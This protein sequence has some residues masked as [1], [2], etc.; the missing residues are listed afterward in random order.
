[1]VRE[2]HSVFTVTCFYLGHRYSSCVKNIRGLKRFTISSLG[3]Y[4]SHNLWYWVWFSLSLSVSDV[5]II[6]DMFLAYL[7]H[8][9]HL[10]ALYMIYTDDVRS[11]AI[12]AIQ[13]KSLF[14]DT[15]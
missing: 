12:F 15:I 14:S 10:P 3:K 7:F 9:L 8:P 11:Y 1:M 2:H 5:D 4:Y 13:S 6:N